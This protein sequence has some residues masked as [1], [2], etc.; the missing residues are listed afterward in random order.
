MKLTAKRAAATALTITMAQLCHTAHAGSEPYFTPLTQSS[1]VASPNHVNELNSPWQAPA[2]ITSTNLVNMAAVEADVNQSIQ[3]VP[4]TGNS[5]T[6]FDMLAY[7]P[8]G[9]WLYLNSEGRNQPLW[10]IRV[11][12]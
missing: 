7:D 12:Q 5:Q 10:K 9:Q 4:G 2:G 3:R 6:M 8:T 1:A 11:P